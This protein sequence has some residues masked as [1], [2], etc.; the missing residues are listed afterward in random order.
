MKVISPNDPEHDRLQFIAERITRLLLY[1]TCGDLDEFVM[2]CSAVMTRV[3]AK[4]TDYEFDEDNLSSCIT[5]VTL[6]YKESCNVTE[7]RNVNLHHR[8]LGK[9]KG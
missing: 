3:L 5:Q 1:L 2:V 4:M 7:S 8:R 6:G 9:G